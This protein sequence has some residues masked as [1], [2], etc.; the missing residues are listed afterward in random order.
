MKEFSIAFV[1]GKNPNWQ[2]YEVHQYNTTASYEEDATC[3]HVLATGLEK[4]H[5]FLFVR[6]LRKAWGED[7]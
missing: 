4:R 2:S 5:A 6:A 1:K 7:E 3:L